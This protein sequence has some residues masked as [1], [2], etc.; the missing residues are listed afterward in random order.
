MLVVLNDS[1]YVCFALISLLFLWKVV[2]FFNNQRRL[3][4][5][6]NNLLWYSRISILGT[7]SESAKQ[8][9]ILLNKISYG[10]LALI[11]AEVIFV[12]TI[13]LLGGN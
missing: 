3:K 11:F 9:K 8:T 13:L 10:I 6:F 2:L 1:I 5:N 4:F 7:Y 12:F